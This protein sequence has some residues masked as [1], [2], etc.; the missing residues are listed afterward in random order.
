[1]LPVHLAFSWLGVGR[2]GDGRLF[3]RSEIGPYV[4]GLADAFERVTV[5]VYDVP[6]TPVG[7][8]DVADYP[9]TR[10]NVRLLSL[11]PKGSWRDYLVRR[12]R[13]A[14]IVGEA[15]SDW[16]VLLVRFDRRAHLVVDANRSKRTVAMVHGYSGA[17]AEPGLT[18][19][20][21][22][23][24]VPFA[25]R[26]RQQLRRIVRSSGLMVTD[27]EHYLAAYGRLA[28]EAVI[29]RHS[30]RRKK[31]SYRSAD[32]LDVPEPRFLFVGR[33][34]TRKGIFE[35]IE[36]FAKIRSALLPGAFLDVVGEGPELQAA[37]A[38]AQKL[39][40]A[41]AVAFHGSIPPGD[42]LFAMY[43]SADV[44]LF[45][46]RSEAFPKVV[47]EA[48]AHSVL[49]ISTRVGALPLAFTSDEVMFV[50]PDPERVAA[51]V[52]ILLREPARRRAMMERGRRWARSTSLE[53][54]V[55]ALAAAIA[56]RWPDIAGSKAQP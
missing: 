33:L 50:D 7:A 17:V 42:P 11:G 4:E 6:P 46:S 22:L 8:E 13:V 14:E 20:D 10:D 2:E 18:L 41:D 51:A 1:M 38:L 43:R 21:R 47:S 29:I 5:L 36:A 31:W 45:L 44:L 19:F 16:D 34:S 54:V 28:D 53:E 15:S 26:T 37:R 52:G 12:K 27:G 56:R 39:D 55:R 3:V 24:L 49:V 40:V 48:L 25:F 23:R 32:R 35:T 30:L 9:V